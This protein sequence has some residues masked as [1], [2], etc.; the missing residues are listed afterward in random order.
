MPL[1][2]VI[3]THE[4]S[5]DTIAT[6]VQYGRKLGKTVIVV[7]DGPGFYVNRILSPYIGEA[8]SCST[9]AQASTP[10]MRR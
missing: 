6:V 3:V 7:E 2:E 4:T 5:A 9:R 10:S 8:E 1:L